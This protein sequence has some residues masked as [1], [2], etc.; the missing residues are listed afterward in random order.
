MSV[1]VAVIKL[2]L[3]H[4]RSHFQFANDREGLSNR[5]DP[6]NMPADIGG[7]V[8]SGTNRRDLLTRNAP[9]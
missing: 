3:R 6:R 5:P 1:I 7:I 9:L 8:P 2:R 4:R